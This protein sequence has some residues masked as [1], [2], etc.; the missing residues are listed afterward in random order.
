MRIVCLCGSTK[1]LA[2]ER[3][4]YFNETM[5]GNIVLSHSGKRTTD[6]IT[7][8]FLDQLHFKKIEMSDEI[9]VLNIGGYIGESTSNEIEHA[10]RLGKLIRYFE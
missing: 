1:F 9:I 10:R 7:G 2:E 4:A 8:G 6:K 3:I 5:S